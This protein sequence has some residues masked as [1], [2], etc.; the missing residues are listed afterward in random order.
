MRRCRGLH[1]STTLCVAVLLLG[2]CSPSEPN[3]LNEMKSVRMTIKGRPFQ[4]W[5][6]DTFETQSR[7]L[8]FITAEQLAPLPDGTERG[9]LFVFDFSTRDSFWMK[10]TIVPLDIAYLSR[11]GTVIKTYTMAPLDDHSGKYPPGALYRYAIE[12]RGQLF[13]QLSLSPGEKLVLPAQVLKDA[14]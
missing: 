8:M 13:N 4:L 9:M 6:A 2:A 3:R 12:V 11:D 14:S 1:R 5:V 7:G 10:N